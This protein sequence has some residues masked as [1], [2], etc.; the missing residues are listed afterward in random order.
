MQKG[1]QPKLLTHQ[2]S[3]RAREQ[4]A[5]I[6]G[7]AAGADA[8]TRAAAGLRELRLSWGIATAPAKPSQRG[9]LSVERVY[10]PRDGL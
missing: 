5:A 10:D 9:F 1:A 4:V 8:R 6:R 3:L 7:A 2:E